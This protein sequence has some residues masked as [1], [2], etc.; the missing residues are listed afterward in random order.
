[1]M[2]FDNDILA[3][4]QGLVAF[5]ALLDVLRPLNGPSLREMADNLKLGYAPIYSVDD[6]PLYHAMGALV[7][8]VCIYLDALEF[9]KQQAAGDD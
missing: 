4:R 3:D 8:D 7:E 2:E 5:N 1:M 6:E 9:Y